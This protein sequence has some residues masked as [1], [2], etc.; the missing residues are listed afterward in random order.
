MVS[1]TVVIAGALAQKPRQGGHTWQFLQY[2]LGF[3]RLGWEVLFLD[4]LEP[5]M[6]VDATGQPC[7]L[8]QSV[9]LRYLVEVMTS[10][11][12]HDAYALIYNRGEQFIGLSRTEVLERVRNSAIL[13]NFMG[14][15]S[16]EEILSRA[17]QRVFLDTDPGFG[18]MWHDLGLADI[19][20]GHDDYVTIGEN[21]GQ[22]GC[23]IPTCGL[24][25]IT[26]RQPVLLEQWPVQP[27][28][29][30]FTSIGSWR[31]P[32]GPLEYHGKT[33][34]LRVHEFRQF[35][36]LPRL[37]GRPFQLALDI[38]A[39]EQKDIGLLET[40]GWALVDPTVVT[41]DP[42]VYRAYIQSSLAELMVAKGMY[43][44]SNSG[45][46]SERSMCY[47]ASGKPV[48]AQDTG[49]QRLYP[50]GE[51]LLTFRTLE[52]ARA[53]V[54]EIVGDHARHARAA[55][56]LAEEYFDSDKVLRGLL[57]KLGIG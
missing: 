13:L 29:K 16:D 1:E 54:E 22:P 26:M 12:L 27:E 34:G 53:G 51:G 3:K 11:D 42:Q 57:A 44:Q 46:F 43:V 21:I 7:P 24:P 47:L 10:F 52:E 8:E 17:P 20:H 4:Q 2:L 50:I 32:Y 18:Q 23:T 33:Y 35:A 28:G 9:N 39:A 14:Y 45:W 56:A 49:L 48:L 6:C 38:H 40:N 37:S 25:W 19:F 55:R 36:P 15:L 31:G 30:C 5:E 41:R